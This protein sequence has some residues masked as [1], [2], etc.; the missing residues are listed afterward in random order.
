MIEISKNRLDELKKGFEGKRIAVIGDM[1]L[2]G[3]YWGDVKRI[4]PEAPVPVLEVEEEFFRFGGAANVALNIQTLGGTPIPVG[5]IGYDNY[6]TIFSSLMKDKNIDDDYVLVDDERPTTTKTRVIANSQHVVRIDKESKS[7]I[8]QKIEEKIIV[9]LANLV[10]NLDGIILQDYNKGVLTPSL[11]NKVISI[12]K[13][14]NILTTVDPK[15]DNFFDFKNVTVFKPN[16]IETEAVLG[17]KI[18]SDEDISSAGERLLLELNAQYVLL[19]L[20]EKGI[21]V[22]EKDGTEKRMATIARKVADVSGAGDTVI[23]TLTIAL[24]AGANVYEAS[25]LANYAAG[26]VCGEVGIVPIEKGKL[27]ETVLKDSK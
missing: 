20:G 23:S 27:F 21:A 19:T 6:G 12:S 5:V 26:I 25:F 14:K 24:A 11:I 18:I 9:Q 1:M 4:S 8:S 3:Y 7:N 13:Q 2:D 15:F 17:M 22:F 16:L 10:N